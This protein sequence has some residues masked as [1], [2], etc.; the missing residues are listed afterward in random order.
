MGRRDR[1]AAGAPR[2]LGEYRR[3]RREELLAHGRHRPLWPVQRAALRPRRPTFPRDRDCVPDHSEHCPRWLEVWNLVFM[4]F[5]RAADGTL[6]PLPFKSVDTGMGLE[7]IARSVQGVDS[8][9]RHRPVRADHRAPGGVHRPR[10]GDGRV[11]AVQLPGRGRPF[12][13]DDVPHRRGDRAVER[14]CRLRPAPHHSP[15]G[16]PRPPDGHRPAIPARDVRGGD[17][18]HGRAPIRI[19][20]RSATGSS[21]RWRPRRR[22]SPARSR[23]GARAWRLWL[24]AEASSAETEAFRLHDTFGFPIDLT[25]E[26]AAESRRD[27][28]PR[29]LRGGDGRAAGAVARLGARRAQPAGRAQRPEQRIHRL[30][31]PDR[32]RGAVRHRGGRRHPTVER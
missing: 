30:P 26:M 19:S 24:P 27:R 22:S 29:R 16:A 12:A 11:G 1:A 13:G 20:S 28:R 2:P 18:P 21:M 5:D 25:V 17:R 31:E 32:C 7:R 14:R 3:R 9:Y 4:E 10:P 6:T 23:R 15:R 8:N